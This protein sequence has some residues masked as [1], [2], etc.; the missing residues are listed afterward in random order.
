[1]TELDR[2]KLTFE[3]AESLEPLPTQ[4]KPTELPPGLRA[5]LW[6]ALYVHLEA[7][8]HR[9]E[10]H[11]VFNEPWLSILRD[12]DVQKHHLPVNKFSALTSGHIS[13]LEK[14]MMS[15]SYSDVFG[16]LQWLLRHPRCPRLLH[17]QVA[18]VLKQHQAGYRLQENGTPTFFPIT[19]E[20]DAKVAERAFAALNADV[21]SG[22][23]M[24]LITAAERLTAGDW[25]GVIRES[26]HTV[27][28][29]VRVLTG[30][31]QDFGKAIAVL[32]GRW[33]I[34][35][36]LKRAFL[37]LYGYTS[38][39]PGIRHAL[40]DDAKASVDEVD[41]LFMFGACSSFVS[42]LIGKERQSGASRA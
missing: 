30:Q 9:L 36:S 24:H 13:A 41:A 16:L 38:D 10:R 2:A 34:H 27:E 22:A 18:N 31:K 15:G 40:V 7:A 5:G 4:L 21:Y 11:S 25:P 28:S 1:M 17:R 6:Q 26:I 39:E 19:S 29:V 32:E 3:Q 35:G 14:T 8:V 20:E 33:S 12:L 42:Y 37:S 23:R